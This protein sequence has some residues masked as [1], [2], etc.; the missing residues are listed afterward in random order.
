MRH[1]KV[2]SGAAVLAIIGA[3]VL[4]I[5][6]PR[7][8][9]QGRGA[10]PTATAD[11]RYDGQATIDRIKPMFASVPKI[12][13]VSRDFTGT[14]DGINPRG[15]QEGGGNCGSL[16]DHYGNPRQLCEFPVDKLEP[17]MNGRMRAWIEFFDEPLSP[18]WDCVGAG[19]QTGLQE[20]YLWEFST[21][22]DMLIQR[23]EQ[24]NWVRYIYMDGRPH[25]P[26][27][28]IYYH[29]HSIGKVISPTEIIVDSTNF[30]FDPD[31]WDDHSHLATSTRKHLIEHYRLTS[32]DTLDVQFTIEDPIFLKQPFTWG[33]HYQKTTQPFV[34]TWDCDAEAGHE[35]LYRTIPQKY[36]DD[37]EFKKYNKEGQ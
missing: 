27:T 28:E 4:V 19:I 26:E 20:G 5:S 36:P 15:N 32:V 33:H 9:A 34:S 30:T 22:A 25:P 24:S 29:G 35:E 16:K 8:G 21:T 23:W 13:P 1:T 18:R 7:L 37:S 2:I 11:P 12:S 17:Y 10:A 31:G 3:A 14:W 6:T